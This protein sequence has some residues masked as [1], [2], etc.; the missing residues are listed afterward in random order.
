MSDNNGIIGISRTDTTDFE[1]MVLD[2]ENHGLVHWITSNEQNGHTYRAAVWTLPDEQLPYE[3]PYTFH[4][5]ETFTVLEGVLE[6]TWSDGTQT[7]LK[8][9]DI[10]SVT[11]GTE[12]NWRITEPFKKFVVEVSL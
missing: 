10:I 8:A 12:S 2:G 3:S 1:P 5:H 7:S 11:G 9:G 6:I 4:N